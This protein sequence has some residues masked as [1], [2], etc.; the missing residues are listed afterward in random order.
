M[1]DLE[2][3][4]P[5]DRGEFGYHKYRYIDEELYRSRVIWP[6]WSE[7][8]V[9]RMQQRALPDQRYG[10]NNWPVFER[11]NYTGAKFD[12]DEMKGKPR[13][14]ENGMPYIPLAHIL[15]QQP[16]LNLFDVRTNQ[17]NVFDQ[18]GEDPN[19]DPRTVRE[20]E[21]Q[22]EWQRLEYAK[23][24]HLLNSRGAWNSHKQLEF[25]WKNRDTDPQLELYRE[26]PQPIDVVGRRQKLE[27]RGL[28][29]KH[30]GS[31]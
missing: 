13:P 19:S 9:S 6:A 22:K 5:Y 26:E 15:E 3:E 10:V 8:Q 23:G 28:L 25:I 11:R 7:E 31:E 21:E 16:A 14:L 2:V 29:R 18:I 30:D 27:A 20:N 12:V 4:V 1:S 17:P 24:Y